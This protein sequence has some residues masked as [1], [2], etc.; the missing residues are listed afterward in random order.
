MKYICTLK[1]TFFSIFI[2]TT[3]ERWVEQ[4]E[5]IFADSKIALDYFLVHIAHFYY[6]RFHSLQFSSS[7][8]VDETTMCF[9][10]SSLQTFIQ[11]LVSLSSML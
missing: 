3:C 1:M 6:F 2:V 9:S 11:L 8:Y 5:C 10:S 7:M 4:V